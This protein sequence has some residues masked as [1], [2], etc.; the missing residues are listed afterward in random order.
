MSIRTRRIIAWC[1][2]GI[3]TATIATILSRS[4][5]YDPEQA[6]VPPALVA[7]EAATIASSTPPGLYPSR[8]EIPALKINAAVQSLGVVAGNR[9]QAPS[10]FRDIGWYKY[11]PVPGTSGTAV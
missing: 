8:V 11:G 10:N 2:L 6:I 9:M 5:F 4:L 3:A 7:F 1:V